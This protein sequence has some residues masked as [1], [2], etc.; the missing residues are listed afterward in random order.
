MKAHSGKYNLLITTGIQMSFNMQRYNVNNF[1]K[2]KLT[3]IK[4]DL[5]LSFRRST[6]DIS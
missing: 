2:E 5:K 3:D 6:P 1:K 4:R